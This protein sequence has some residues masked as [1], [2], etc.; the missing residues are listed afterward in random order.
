MACTSPRIIIVDGFLEDA[1]CNAL[2]SRALPNLQRS[3][4]GNLDEP[5][6]DEA[7]SI[8][9]DKLLTRAAQHDLHKLCLDMPAPYAAC[10]QRESAQAAPPAPQQ[11]QPSCATRCRSRWTSSF[12]RPR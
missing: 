2:M 11:Q 10:V 4:V 7:T 5:G 6:M 1:L 8:A 12:T 9:A 3:L